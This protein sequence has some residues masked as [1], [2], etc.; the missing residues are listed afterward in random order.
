MSLRTAGWS[1]R[2]SCRE[3]ATLDRTPETGRWHISVAWKSTRRLHDS[4]SGR[5]AHC[6][7]LK[8]LSAPHEMVACA[9]VSSGGTTKDRS[10]SGCHTPRTLPSLWPRAAEWARARRSTPQL[11]WELSVFV[12]GQSMQHDPSE[13]CMQP[14]LFCCLHSRQKLCLLPERDFRS[15]PRAYF[16]FCQP[17]QHASSQHAT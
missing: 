12:P 14:K 4:S 10:R 15:S 8:T 9:A 16:C 5:P 2:A 11:S 17:P 6:R 13:I 3:L 7:W 1:S